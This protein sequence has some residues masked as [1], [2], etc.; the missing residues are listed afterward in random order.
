MK[1]ITTKTIKE[2]IQNKIVYYR[3]LQD[4]ANS[5]GNYNTAERYKFYR[6]E[7]EDLLESLE[8]NKSFNIDYAY[9]DIAREDIE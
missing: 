5:K 4:K 6:W 9:Y 1:K 3:R 2:L 7:L 8:N